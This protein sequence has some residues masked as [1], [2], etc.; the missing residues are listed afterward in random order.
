MKPSSA[1]FFMPQADCELKRM[2]TNK[3]AF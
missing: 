1:G 3:N 2:K